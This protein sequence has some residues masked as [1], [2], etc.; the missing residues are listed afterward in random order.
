MTNGLGRRA[1]SLLGLVL[2][3]AISFA[4]G[5][6]EGAPDE[7]QADVSAVDQA[8]GMDAMKAMLIDGFERAKAWDLAMAEG[9][10]DGYNHEEIGECLLAL[11]RPDEARPHFARAYEILSKD[12]WLADGEPER[13]KRLAE[14]GRP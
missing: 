7:A 1:V 8:S 12:A 3:A 5:C 4:W 10:P 9:I 2:V 13:L 11:G 14:L 6:A